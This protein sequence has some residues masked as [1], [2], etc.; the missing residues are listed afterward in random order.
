M[1]LEWLRVTKACGYSHQEQ[2]LLSPDTCL[3]IPNTR[4]RYYFLAKHRD[5][6]QGIAHLLSATSES[7]L[8]SCIET[9]LPHLQD[10]TQGALKRMTIGEIIAPLY[11]SPYFLSKSSSERAYEYHQQLLIP[12]DIL[13][14]SWAN[15]MISIATPNDSLTYCFTKGYGKRYDHSTGSCYLPPLYG[16]DSVIDRD[17]LL[18]YKDRLRRF[19]PDELLLLFG[20]PLEYRWPSLDEEVTLSACYGCIGNSISVHVVREVMCRLFSM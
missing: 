20:F 19:H 18:Q 11:Q 9:C 3:G 4:S 16:V 1:H 12:T 15:S 6:G 14:S 13:T 2:Y 7:A 10:F 5:S 8:C 17:N